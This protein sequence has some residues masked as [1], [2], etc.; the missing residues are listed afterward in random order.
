MENRHLRKSWLIGGGVL[1]GLGLCAWGFYTHSAEADSDLPEAL[2]VSGI[3]AGMDDPGRSRES[4]RALM[5]DETLTEDQRRRAAKN[6][7]TV[8]RDEMKKR[9]DEYFNA[10]ED[11]QQAIL[12]AQI[13]EFQA[14]M[15]A[16]RKRREEREKQADKD[17]ND[18]RGGF[19]GMFGQ[20]SKQERKEAT[21]SRNP[22]D[23]ARTMAYFQAMRSRMSERGMQMP[24]RGG[25]RHGGSGGT[26]P[27]RG[28]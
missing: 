27:G 23:M 10:D 24:G 18:D 21:E 1:L 16:W 3:R 8:W 19:R 20:R 11:E 12:D 5:R 2:T 15:N 17:G 7:R 22:D 26:R 14:R 9:V 6:M 28:P 25:G 13:D 4:F